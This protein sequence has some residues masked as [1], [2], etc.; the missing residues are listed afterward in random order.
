VSGKLRE[1]GVAVEDIDLR[2]YEM[3]IFNE[4]SKP[5]TRRK[6]QAGSPRNSPRRISS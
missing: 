1:A 4:T 5:R 3:P 2:D 6:R